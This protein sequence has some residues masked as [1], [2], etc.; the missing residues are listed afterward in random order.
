MRF[1][2]ALLALGF[3]G[4]AIYFG[5]LAKSSYS[6]YSEEQLTV[7]ADGFARLEHPTEA[8]DF[9][10]TL[11]EEEKR[12]R[13][14][15]PLMLV[16]AVL[17]A[18]GV[19]LT[20]AVRESFSAPEDA[21]FAATVGNPSLVLEG[22]KNKAATLL[23]V[24]VTAPPAVIEAALTAQLASRDPSQMQGMAPD[25]QKLVNDQRDALIKARDLLLGRS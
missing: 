20:R 8:Q 11:F 9:S 21:R 15:F 18:I 7:L 1:V 13:L 2:F 4:G 12:R 23:G 6:A 24:T 3:V 10:R 22:A 14:F 16:G 25:L 19:Y 5:A 17:S